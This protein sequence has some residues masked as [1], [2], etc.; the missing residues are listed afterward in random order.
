NDFH[1]NRNPDQL[2]FKEDGQYVAS[3]RRGE[4]SHGGTWSVLG[5]PGN[6]KEK[7]LT[8]HEPNMC[9]VRATEAGTVDDFHNLPGLHE[10]QWTG[11]LMFIGASYYP[12]EKQT[13]KRVFVWEPDTSLRVSGEYEGSLV[14]GAAKTIRLTYAATGEPGDTAFSLVSLRVVLHKLKGGRADGEEAVLLD[15]P[16]TN[17]TLASKRSSNESHG[18]TYTDQIEITPPVHGEY[19]YLK[20][21]VQLKDRYREYSRQTG[22]ML[23]IGDK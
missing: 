11:D 9:D 14:Q 8:H 15:K 16:Y 3:Y 2:T 4:C 6:R 20:L 19:C 17:V 18:G 22:Y 23:R 10:I 21:I 7:L 1:L 12:E 13:D 5:P